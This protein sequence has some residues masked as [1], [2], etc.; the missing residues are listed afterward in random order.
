MLQNTKKKGKP[1][2][3]PEFLENVVKCNVQGKVVI[4]PLSSEKAAKVVDEKF[5]FI[6]INGDHG[7]EAVSRDCNLWLPHL[8]KNGV[9][10]FH[11]YK[12]PPIHKFCNELKQNKNLSVILELH[13]IIAF[14]HH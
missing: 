13:N 12:H 11:D 14:R 4:L 7:Y 1:W 2:A 6:F 9:L 3:F 5:C 8:E 10:I